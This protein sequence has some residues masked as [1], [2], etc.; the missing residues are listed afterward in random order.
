MMI[1]V[2]QLDELIRYTNVSNGLMLVLMK[3]RTFGQE[4]KH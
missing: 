2:E 1:V 4:Q 3:L